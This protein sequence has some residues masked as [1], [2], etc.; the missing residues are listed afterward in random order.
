M[1]RPTGG[2]VQFDGDAAFFKPAPA[3]L[4]QL[5]ATEGDVI[6]REEADNENKEEEKDPV[7]E[8]HKTT[9]KKLLEKSRVQGVV[10]T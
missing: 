5:S 6:Q 4:V 1:F 9:G 8:G 3:P 7:T 2:P 10:Q